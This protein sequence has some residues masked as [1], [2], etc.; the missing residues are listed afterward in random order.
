MREKVARD[1]LSRLPIPLAQDMGSSGS[2]NWEFSILPCIFVFSYEKGSEFLCL[3][4]KVGCTWRNYWT[5]QEEP[6]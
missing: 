1:L 4:N 3:A 5:F 6:K 2:G